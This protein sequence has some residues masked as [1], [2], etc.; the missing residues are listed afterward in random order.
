MHLLGWLEVVEGPVDLS[1]ALSVWRHLARKHVRKLLKLPASVQ[2]HVLLIEQ[3]IQIP[4]TRIQNRKEMHTLV[5][6]ISGK[7]T[8]L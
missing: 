4:V 6:P 7:H 5:Q 8:Y 2:N 3:M 1:V